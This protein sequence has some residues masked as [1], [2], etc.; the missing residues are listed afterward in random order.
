MTRRRGEIT[1]GD[2]KRKWP[3]HVRL[4]AESNRHSGKLSAERKSGAGSL[5]LAQGGRGVI[6]PSHRS[7]QSWE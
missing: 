5:A 1:R 6:K 7:P 4:P 3:H 2:L